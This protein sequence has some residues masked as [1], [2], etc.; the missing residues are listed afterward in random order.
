MIAHVQRL[1][2]V[3]KMATLLQE[4]NTEKQRS[5]VRILWAKGFNA[6]DI[7]KEMFPV[8]GGKWL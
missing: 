1:V 6:K 7:Q 2:S 4:C 5:V 3:V 8:Y